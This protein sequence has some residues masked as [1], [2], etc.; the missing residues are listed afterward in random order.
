MSIIIAFERAQGHGNARTATTATVQKIPKTIRTQEI[1]VPH[2]GHKGIRAVSELNLF[3]VVGWYGT[4]QQTD[5]N[6]NV[7]TNRSEQSVNGQGDKGGRGSHTSYDKGR[8]LA[9]THGK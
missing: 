6:I 4:T 3:G 1:T 2:A 8:R 7:V 9:T 5:T